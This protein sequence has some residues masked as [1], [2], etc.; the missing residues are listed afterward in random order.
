MV[1]GIDLGGTSITL[2]QLKNGKLLQKVTIA[3]P[4]DK[5]LEESLQSIKNVIYS[6][7]SSEVEGIGIGVPSVVD[8]EKGIVYNVAN[9]PSWKEVHLKEILEKEFGVRV[10]VN[11]DANCFALGEFH[12]GAV[13]NYKSMVGLTL[14]TGVGA[15]IIIE[16]KLYNGFNTGAGEIG[17]IAYQDGIYEDY[18]ASAFF[19]RQ[20]GLSGKEAARLAREGNQNAAE[21][22]REFGKHL[23][24]L[25]QTIL[26]AYDPQSIVIG[27]SIS[28]AFPYFKESMYEQMN[29]FPYPETLKRL[30]IDISHEE[31]VA[32]LGAASLMYS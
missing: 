22:W 8:V 2:G 1:I 16:G 14:G 23:G 30:T 9:I 28:K 5:N 32:I 12:S 19:S 18:C 7:M 4:A 25:M 17:S 10:C 26:F 3:S 15:G 31:H 29:S 13:K 6:L 20:Y 24:N 21:I 11:N 27:G